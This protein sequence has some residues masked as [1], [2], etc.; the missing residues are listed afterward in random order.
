M[1]STE[2]IRLFLS[3]LSWII[4][5]SCTFVTVQE[6]T[7]NWSHVLQ[8]FDLHYMR[9]VCLMDPLLL[10]WQQC[11]MSGHQ[12]AQRFFICQN[13]DCFKKGSAPAPVL[14]CLS[15]VPLVRL[16]LCLGHIEWKI[17]TKISLKQE[18]WFILKPLRQER[19]PQAKAGWRLYTTV[20]AYMTENIFSPVSHEKAAL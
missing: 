6:I 4:I 13:Q 19:H 8:S 18:L 20:Q 5:I 7:M 16:W 12:N 2:A 17:E 14:N 3:T 11:I 15:W 10:K 1:H 9:V